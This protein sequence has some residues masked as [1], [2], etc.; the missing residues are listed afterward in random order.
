MIKKIKDALM[1][2]LK[3][4]GYDGGGQIEG[5]EDY[6]YVKYVTLD[7]R[8]SEEH[9]REYDNIKFDI[10]KELVASSVSIKRVDAYPN[11][12]ACYSIEVEY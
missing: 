8:L 4:F 11:G 6:F 7:D 5:E 9:H 3:K 12:F 2:V 1:K 10:E